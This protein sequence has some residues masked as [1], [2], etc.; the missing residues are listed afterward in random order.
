MDDPRGSDPE[1]AAVDPPWLVR[2]RYWAVVVA[3]MGFISYLSTDAFSAT[4]TNLYMDPVLR[5]IFPDVSNADLRAAHTVIRKTA[6]FTEFFV[7]SVLVVWAQ[8]AGR[9][10]PWLPRWMVNALLLVAAYASL[11]EFH[12]SFSTARTPSFADTGVDILGGAVGQALLYLRH[13]LRTRG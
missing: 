2:L 4:N 5:W 6:H 8:R 12:Q 9:P 11:D 7:L 1:V 13:R 3:W 10:I